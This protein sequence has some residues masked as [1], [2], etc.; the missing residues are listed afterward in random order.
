MDFFDKLIASTPIKPVPVKVP[1]KIKHESNSD[2]DEIEVL[3]KN[4]SQMGNSQEGT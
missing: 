3:E 1:K 4:E 2:S